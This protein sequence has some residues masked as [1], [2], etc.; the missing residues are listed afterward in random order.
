MYFLPFLT[1]NNLQNTILGVFRCL[2][3]KQIYYIYIMIISCFQFINF[4][5]FHLQHVQ[6]T[7][8]GVFYWLLCKQSKITIWDYRSSWY[9][10]NSSTFPFSQMHFGHHGNHI[11]AKMYCFERIN[12]SST[13]PTFEKI[14]YLI[15]KPLQKFTLGGSY[16]SPSATHQFF[17]CVRIMQGAKVR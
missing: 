5:H 9:G 6:S 8:L 7:I 15:E 4:F 1:T 13:S 12:F 17:L 11:R 3:N 14:S 10:F 2:L 16:N